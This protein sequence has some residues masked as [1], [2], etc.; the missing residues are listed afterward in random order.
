MCKLYNNLWNKIQFYSEYLFQNISNC[1][2][3][4]FQNI[5]NCRIVQCSPSDVSWC[6]A[7]LPFRFGG[8]G[9]RESF[10]S[11]PTAFLGS[12][13]SVRVLASTILSIDIDQLSF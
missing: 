9:L 5:Y 11:V 7:S 12:C 8:L 1:R 4:Q 13:N 3:V 2:I 10:V 6:Q